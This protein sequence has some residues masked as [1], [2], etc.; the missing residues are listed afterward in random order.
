MATQP[1]K[2]SSGRRIPSVTTVISRFKESG[3]LLYWANQQGLEGKTLD[4][5]RHEATTP[6]TIGH[7]M[8]EAHIHGRAY[9]VDEGPNDL[10]EKARA[11]FAA[12]IAWEQMT[13]ISFRHTEVPLT[14]GKHRFGGTL[15][16]IG[17]IG[18]ELVLCDWKCANA[19]YAD[20]LY[21]LAAYK[22]LWEENYPEH[23]IAGGFHL[24]RFSKEQ[25]DFSHHFF[26][27]LDEEAETFLL[28]RSLYDRVKR[29]DKRV[30]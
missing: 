28:M 16:A 15:D 5:A 10:L 22:I 30:R 23:L 20:Y 21:Q 17:L 13:A 2:D 7:Q 8:V 26:P 18:N 9:H 6:G 1:Y 19:V 27:S 12:Y 14:S 3:G 4:D 24:C 29:T 11:A 25:G